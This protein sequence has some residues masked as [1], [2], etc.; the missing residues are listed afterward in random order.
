[1]LDYD[2]CSLMSLMQTRSTGLTVLARRPG[3]RRPQVR[4]R[5]VRPKRYENR[6]CSGQTRPHHL[7]RKAMPTATILLVYRLIVSP[8]LQGQNDDPH[9]TAWEV[10][11]SDRLRYP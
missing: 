9:V 5:P 4:E 2:P 6:A 1:M 11:L 7:I 3:P 10:P 8:L